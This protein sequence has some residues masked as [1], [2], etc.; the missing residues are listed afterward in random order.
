MLISTH[1]LAN[2]DLMDGVDYYLRTASVLIAT[3]FLDEFERSAKLIEQFPNL[4]TKVDGSYRRLPLHR[5]PYKVVYFVTHNAIRIIA[6][7]H[8]RRVPNYWHDRV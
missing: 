2:Q 8:D 4:A 6:V 3:N 5:Y 7:A 1:P